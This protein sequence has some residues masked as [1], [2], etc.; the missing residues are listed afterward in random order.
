MRDERLRAASSDHGDA[1]PAIEHL[2]ILATALFAVAIAA[3][4]VAVLLNH[5]SGF[6]EELALSVL[7]S[8]L[9]LAAMAVVPYARSSRRRWRERDTH[10]VLVVGL[11][12]IATAAWCGNGDS[13]AVAA[14]GFFAWIP[15]MAFT[16]LSWRRAVPY[17][18]ASS[19][20]CV[21]VVVTTLRVTAAGCASDAVGTALVSAL[22]AAYLRT[23]LTRSAAT[24]PLTRLPNRQ[25]L[26][27]IFRR[28]KGRAGR[29]GAAL[30]VAV[31]DLD[32]FKAVNDAE[33]HHAGDRLLKEAAGRWRRELRP[34]D[35][36][37]RYGGDEFV[38]VLPG[39]DRRRAA[40]VLDGMRRSGGLAFSAGVAQWIP[41]ESAEVTL[42]RA[43]AAL[44]RAK[45]EGRDRV[46]TAE[47]PDGPV[48]PGATGRRWGRSLWALDPWA[49]EGNVALMLTVAGTLYMAAGVVYLPQVLLDPLPNVEL[50]MAFAVMCSALVIGAGI[51]VAARRL[52][53]RL[54]MWAVHASIALSIAAVGLGAASAYG[55]PE[56][57]LALGIFTWVWL[58]AFAV[59]PW[60]TA[61]AYC[62]AGSAIVVAYVATSIHR[63]PA[64]VALLVLCSS[65][66]IGVLVGYLRH[67]LQ[68]QA[69]VDAV[70]GLPNRGMLD[71]A[72]D[73]EIG[74]AARRA[75][76]LSVG[77]VDL[78]H[79][80]ALNDTAGH[81]AGD[82][83]LREF[84]DAWTRRLRSVD[85]LVRYGG[86][87]FVVLLPGC[88]LSAGAEAVERLRATGVQPCSVG[89]TE[90]S[91]EDTPESLLSRADTALYRAKR[92]GRDRV[93]SID[94]PGRCLTPGPC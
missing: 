93:V 53:T 86:D 14:I 35:E 32:H 40:T 74:M 85:S 63:N 89:L 84:A 18:V 82:R 12:A 49:A 54:G 27:H 55:G 72:L 90:W 39:C 11:A 31:V 37:V 94:P 1:R 75:E 43:D 91:P 10:V 56:S 59:L 66:G 25:A 58:F 9:V 76:P 28:E 24:D 67:L 16:F 4:L 78:D 60:R 17:L 46:A 26:P 47:E 34:G 2:G 79:F 8:V 52:G 61:S 92:E 62:A 29:T 69:L 38:V 6:R 50:A 21:V 64:G 20:L 83:R 30:A 22:T 45:H 70:T 19:L 44:Y 36:V 3:G 42:A 57:I 7:G 65:V 33:G 68:R 51:V 13:T 73:R 87:E 71:T 23:M 81:L 48:P 88:D 80:K 77:I 15:L 41:G 5:V